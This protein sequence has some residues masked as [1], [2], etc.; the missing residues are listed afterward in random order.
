MIRHINFTGRRDLP[1]GRFSI[2]L[3]EGPPR[4]FDATI[5]LEDNEFPPDSKLFI[6]AYSSGSSIVERFPWG[7]VSGPQ[8]PEDRLLDK[9]PGSLVLFDFKVVATGEQEGRLLGLSRR[10]SVVTG[11]GRRPLLPVNPTPLGGLVWRVSFM[12]DTPWLEVNNAIPDIMSRVESDSAFRSLVFPAV[13]AEVLQHALILDGIRDAE[14]TDSW[15]GRWLAFAMQLHPTQQPPPQHA[16]DDFS[17][18]LR[19][20]EEA[21]SAYAELFGAADAFRLARPQPMDGPR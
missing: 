13:L 6:E 10:I 19:W 4:S 7:T 18:R 2:S 11:D 20:I 3:T 21:R 5:S 9:I 12:G 16:D 17:D 1:H 14:D 15:Q 8:P